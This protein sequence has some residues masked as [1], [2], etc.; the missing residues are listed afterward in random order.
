MHTTVKDAIVDWFQWYNAHRD[1]GRSV[2]QEIE[3]LKRALDGAFD[4]LAVA[5]QEIERLKGKPADTSL[6]LPRGMVMRK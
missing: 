6:W 1:V 5:A 2:E 4:M 3:F